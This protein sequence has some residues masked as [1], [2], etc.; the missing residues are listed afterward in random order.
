MSKLTTI[1]DLSKILN[2]KGKTNKPANHT[3]RYWEK[4]FK[5]IKPKIINKRRYYSPKQIEIIKLIK[6]LIKDQ[7]MTIV[8]AKNLL[9]LDLNKLDDTDKHSLKTIYYKKYFKDKS[10]NL[11]DRIKK[12]KK[13]G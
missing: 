4:E 2:L 1:S 7:G 5:Q 6:F 11:L 10:K 9:N 3:L 8:G 12:L 13:Y